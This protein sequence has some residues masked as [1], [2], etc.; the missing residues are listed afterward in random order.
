[1]GPNKQSFGNDSGE[2][3]PIRTIFGTRHT[4]Q[5]ATTFRKFSKRFIARNDVPFW[6]VR[7]VPINFGSRPQNE[8]FG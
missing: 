8:I 6:G 1:M 5:E 2:P 7:D 4:G 3:R